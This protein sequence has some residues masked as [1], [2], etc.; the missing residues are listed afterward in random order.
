MAAWAP[1]NREKKNATAALDSGILQKLIWAAQSI[2]SYF[3]VHDDGM[4][5]ETGIH[6]DWTVEEA[7]RIRE[8][9]ETCP[10]DDDDA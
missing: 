9:V 3:W 2:G 4:G 6:D 1:Q 8:I 5:I 7:N 10:V